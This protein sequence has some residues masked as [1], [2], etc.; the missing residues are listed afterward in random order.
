[1]S[2][3]NAIAVLQLKNLAQFHLHITTYLHVNA[4][5]VELANMTVRVIEVDHKPNLIIPKVIVYE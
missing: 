1:M 2:I 5:D 3:A 4:K